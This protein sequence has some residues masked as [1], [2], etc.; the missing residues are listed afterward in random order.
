MEKMYFNTIISLQT[1][2]ARQILPFC[3]SAW[4]VPCTHLSP[5]SIVD[6]SVF[7]IKPISVFF[8]LP[9]FH[10]NLIVFEISLCPNLTSATVYVLKPHTVAE[11][12]GTKSPLGGHVPQQNLPLL[13]LTVS[14]RFSRYTK[15]QVACCFFRGL[16]T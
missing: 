2:F 6:I 9:V 15:H 14:F 12:H 16:F 8:L 10:V 11:P 7:Q 4:R 5:L 3:M 13:L 1:R